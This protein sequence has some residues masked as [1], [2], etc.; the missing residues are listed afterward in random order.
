MK[1]PQQKFEYL[2]GDIMGWEEF[3]THW[4]AKEL[5]Y[6]M[7]RLGKS[8]RQLYRYGAYAHKLREK[9]GLQA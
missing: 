7:E 5:P 9:D 2:H 3:T 1:T 8:E 6:L 4:F